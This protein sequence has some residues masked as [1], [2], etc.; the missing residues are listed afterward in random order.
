MRNVNVCN[1]Y[2]LW[3][4][5]YKRAMCICLDIFNDASWDFVKETCFHLKL[6]LGDKSAT[7]V[8]RLM[9]VL[10]KEGQMTSHILDGEAMKDSNCS[11]PSGR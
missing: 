6:R 7:L 9:Y 8:P 5:T 1:E 3:I 2:I 11:E 10:I 4:V